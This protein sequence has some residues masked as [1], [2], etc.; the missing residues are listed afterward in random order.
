MT[1]LVRRRAGVGPQLPVAPSLL[2]A[3][4]SAHLATPL[5]AAGYTPD[6]CRSEG[7]G[8]SEKRREVQVELEGARRKEKE[9]RNWGGG[10]TGRSHEAWENILPK[11]RLQ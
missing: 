3:P 10:D 4:E 11:P 9:K 5:K 7:K 1:Q 8:R 2:L 6:T